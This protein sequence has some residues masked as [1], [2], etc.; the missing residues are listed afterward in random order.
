MLI[1]TVSISSSLHSS[2]GHRFPSGTEDYEGKI[3]SLVHWMT[4]YEGLYFKLPLATM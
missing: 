3:I 2:C 4:C 1:H